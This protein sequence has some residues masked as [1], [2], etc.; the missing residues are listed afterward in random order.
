MP[1]QSVPCSAHLVV[2][3][4]YF[5]R[6]RIIA[7]DF[8]WTGILGEANSVLNRPRP[9]STDI[10][11]CGRNTNIPV[12]PGHYPGQLRAQE[13]AGSKVQGQGARAGRTPECSSRPR[14]WT[15][16]VCIVR[17]SLSR[18]LPIFESSESLPVGGAPTFLS[19]P[20][21]ITPD[22]RNIPDSPFPAPRHWWQRT[23]LQ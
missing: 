3:K 8:L 17:N 23:S 15:L 6:M 7:P 10:L 18:G 20:G 4:R 9:W 11:V 19:V 2:S 14:L 16:D 5:W 12:N 22:P 13:S 21:P 1:G